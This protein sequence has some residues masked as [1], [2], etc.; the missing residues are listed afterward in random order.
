VF[1]ISLADWWADAKSLLPGDGRRLA[2]LSDAQLQALGRAYA[3]LY[4]RPA[5]VSRTGRIRT[6]GPTAAAK[7]LYFVRPLSPPGIRQ[8]PPGQAGA[9]TM[10][11]S[12]GTSQPA[13]AGPAT[14]K[15]RPP[16]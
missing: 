7:L 15:P 6:V 8:S 5:A 13:E 1:A 14:W 9:A 2:Q 4:R 11:P 16:A 12:C 10:R 3:Q